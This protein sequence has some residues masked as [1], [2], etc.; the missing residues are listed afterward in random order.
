MKPITMFIM[1]SC[2]HCKNALHW[3]DELKQENPQYN[4][5][6]V[7]II[8]E[9][10]QPQIASTYDY[11]YVPTYFVD[12]AKVHEGVPSKAIIRQVFETAL[13]DE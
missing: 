3:M 1:E 11:Y 7:S 13:S 10:A 2:P 9:N 4:N 5:V 12:T 8:D 6:P